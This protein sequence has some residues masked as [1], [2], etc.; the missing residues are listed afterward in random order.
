MGVTIKM[1][2][3]REK[4]ILI[5]SAK[6]HG[7][8]KLYIFGIGGTGSRVI[9]ALSMLLAAGCKLENGFDTVVPVII[10]PDTGNGG[11]KNKRC[12]RQRYLR[13]YSDTLGVNGAGLSCLEYRD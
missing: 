5:D 13:I 10:D 2:T 12:L 7:V 4:K 8:Q 6:K 11:F 9:K 1:I 3:D